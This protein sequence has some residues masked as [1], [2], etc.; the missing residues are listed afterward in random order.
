MRVEEHLK[1]SDESFQF[2]E[3]FRS[4]LKPLLLPHEPRFPLLLDAHGQIAIQQNARLAENAKPAFRNGVEQRRASSL[5]DS[6]RIGIKRKR[7]DGESGGNEALQYRD[8][9]R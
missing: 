5:P 2:R 4:C 7:D 9:A 3:A 8:L 1:F 6:H